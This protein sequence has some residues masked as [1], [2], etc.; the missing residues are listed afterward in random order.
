MKCLF[1][2]IIQ[3]K[4]PAQIIEEK[5]EFIIFKDINPSASIHYLIVPKKH[6]KSIKSAGSEKVAQTLIRAAKK[7]AKRE[8]IEGYKLIFNVGKKGGQIIEHLHL[9]FLAG[10]FYTR[11]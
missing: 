9:H 4:E 10:K 1:C 5:K 6:I 8:K 11:F 7:L 2:K 3:K